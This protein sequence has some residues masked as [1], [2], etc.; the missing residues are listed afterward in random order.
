MGI[1]VVAI[2]Q[3]AKSF[4]AR[5]VEEVEPVGLSADS[6]FLQLEARMSAYHVLWC[7]LL[8]CSH[9]ARSIITNLE[10]HADGRC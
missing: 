10:V 9:W 8:K 2:G 6:Q 3:R 4:L 7:A 1:A 5:R